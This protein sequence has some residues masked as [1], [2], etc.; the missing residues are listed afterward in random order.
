ML[1]SRK[2]MLLSSIAMLLVAL[3]ALG[4]ATFAWYFSNPQVKA[5]EATIG[6]STAE[7]LERIKSVQADESLLRLRSLEAFE[8]VANG[9]ATK[10]IIPSDIQNIAG[11]VTS[12]KELTK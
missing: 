5:E 3:V 1:K 2:K 7:G 12:I 9:Q 10:I 8:K 11:L 4:S 6:A